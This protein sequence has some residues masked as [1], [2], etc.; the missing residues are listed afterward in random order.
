[1]F[2]VTL[3]D[4]FWGDEDFTCSQCNVIFTSRRGASEHAEAK[5]KVR[6]LCIKDRYRVKVFAEPRDGCEVIKDIGVKM[7][8]EGE[9]FE[10]MKEETA[11][12]I[13]KE[14]IKAKEPFDVSTNERRREGVEVNATAG[15][16][17]KEE[18]GEYIEQ[19][20]VESKFVPSSKKF[21]VDILVEE[22]KKEK[23]TKSAVAQYPYGEDCET[24]SDPEIKRES[25]EE[26][27]NLTGDDSDSDTLMTPEQYDR[28]AE[29][30]A[31]YKE[32]LGIND[33]DDSDE[34]EKE[35]TLFLNI[36]FYLFYES[37]RWRK[38]TTCPS[39]RRRDGSISNT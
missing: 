37:L 8:S 23:R 13:K 15:P 5:H 38:F 26:E 32:I 35:V 4:N 22:E 18:P 29:M 16:S 6:R 30:D 34:E 28:Q 1:M 11:D 7:N 27:N 36:S 9:Y 39:A 19:D 2:E 12:E 10:F 24:D 20:E 14:D 31:R 21:K 17:A 33:E 3:S 25:A